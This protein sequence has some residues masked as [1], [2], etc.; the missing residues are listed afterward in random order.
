MGCG[1]F[2]FLYVLKI[3]VV[4]MRV[5]WGGVY[6]DCWVGENVDC[7]FWVREKVF[8]FLYFERWLGI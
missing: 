7:E 5:S 2:L 8:F 3:M 6:E 4:G 1:V